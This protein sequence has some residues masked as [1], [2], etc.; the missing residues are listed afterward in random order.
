[1]TSVF[2]AIDTADMDR[3]QQLAA[4][5][6][7]VG[8]G[9]KLGLEFFY[10]HGPEGLRKIRGAHPDVPLFLDLKLKDIPTTV[11]RAM[12]ALVPLGVDYLNLHA[13]GGFEMMRA[14]LES[15][16][17]ESARLK[18]TAPKIL[19]VTILTSLE[20]SELKETG[21]ADIDMAEHVVSLAK[22][23]KRAGLAGT[24]NA[25]HEISAI[26]AACGDDFVLMVPGIRPLDSAAGDQ[27]RV[28]SPAGAFHA[29]ATHLVIGRPITGA[30]DPCAAARQI[31]QSLGG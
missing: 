7:S 3:A 10:A 27:K 26:R 20:D 13:T 2:C 21:M 15:V 18:I 22:L 28:M 5:M 8:C 31:L 9:I 14:A 17:E 12:A 6:Q 25:G 23:A 30:A 1:M 24:V 16:Q 19:A 11:Q 29:G 4:Q